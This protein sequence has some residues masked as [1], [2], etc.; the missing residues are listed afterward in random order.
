M[1]E[2][3]EILHV[4]KSGRVIVKISVAAREKKAT[5]KLVMDATGRQIGRIQEIFGP[6]ISP[7]ASVQPSRLKLSDI[8]E[9]K[10]FIADEDFLRKT[11]FKSYPG[12]T[13]RDKG[14]PR[15]QRART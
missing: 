10:V 6:V 13:T 5:G 9:T 12:H 11:K 7:Y 4:A 15:S 1:I 14:R 2:L 3:G 8:I